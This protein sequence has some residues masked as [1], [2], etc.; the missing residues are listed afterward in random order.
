MS[1]TAGIWRMNGPHLAFFNGCRGIIWPTAKWSRARLS[2]VFSLAILLLTNGPSLRCNSVLVEAPSKPIPLKQKARITLL[3]DGNPLPGRKIDVWLVNPYRAGNSAASLVTDYDGSV[4][5]PELPPGRYSIAPSQVWPPDFALSVLVCLVPCPD[6]GLETIDLVPTTLHGPLQ[7]VD[8]D[9]LALS[10]LRI[11]IAPTRSLGWIPL[12]STVEQ[13]P[14][15]SRMSELRG[16]VQDR[17]G[18]V[19]PG[20]WIT[21]VVK[22]TEGKKRA[23][24]LRADSIGRFSAHLPEGDYVAIIESPGF[25]VVAVSF[26][27]LSTGTGINLQIVLDVGSTTQT[28]TISD[29]RP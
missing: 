8:R 11:E 9:T 10:E 18:A 19:I 22:G 20:T 26:T 14:I 27:I 1:F 29:L 2:A 5:L 23:A 3:L 13:Q 15:T 28:V 25:K 21:V 12:I 16:V 24:L 17:G 6:D 4:Q 7:V